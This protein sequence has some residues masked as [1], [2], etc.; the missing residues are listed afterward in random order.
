MDEATLDLALSHLAVLGDWVSENITL[1][2]YESLDSEDTIEVD[3]CKTLLGPDRPNRSGSASLSQP[4]INDG[5]IPFEVRHC[6]TIGKA[7][8]LNF[9][10][11]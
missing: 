3:L 4:V 2:V 6:L 1:P 8:F 11:L 10:N 5:S 7:E 9:G